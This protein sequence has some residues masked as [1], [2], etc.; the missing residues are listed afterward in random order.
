MK[1]ANAEP[2]FVIDH[3]ALESF[4]TGSP[5]S[6]VVERVFRQCRDCNTVC[7]TSAW[8]LLAL[9]EKCVRTCP[10]ELETVVSLADQ[11]PLQE[12]TVDRS[13]AVA[14]AQNIAVNPWLDAP[15][16][17][18]LALAQRHGVPLITCKEILKSGQNVL[19]LSKP[20]SQEESSN[21]LEN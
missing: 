4:F 9:L 3:S 6:K 8:D 20:S 7:L 12:L 18:S 21:G 17:V 1:K 2:S 13:L 19:Y 11:L 5:E 15:A 14:A 10:D 16:A